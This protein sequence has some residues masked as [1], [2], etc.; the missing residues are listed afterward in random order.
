MCQKLFLVSWWRSG[1]LWWPHTNNFLEQLGGS[2]I[3]TADACSLQLVA[4]ALVTRKILLEP[5]KYAR[6][7]ESE[8]TSWC[9]SDVDS[10]VGRKAP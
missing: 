6:F 7:V 8:W 4:L 1:V 5:S 10:M 2:K 3:G 9:T